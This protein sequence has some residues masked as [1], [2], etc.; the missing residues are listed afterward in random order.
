M[1]LDHAT[2]RD[3]EIFAST[4]GKGPAVVGLLDHTRTRIG[5]LQLQQ[6]L[7]TPLADAG[8]IVEVQD[9]GRV[10]SRDLDAWRAMIDAACLD[11]VQ[12]YLDLRWQTS[13]RGSAVLRSVE[14][15][16]LRVRHPDFLR[17]ISR[18][19]LHLLAFL[20]AVGDLARRLRA[21][22]SA[23]L[24]ASGM[25]LDDGLAAPPVAELE[26]LARRASSR[27]NH[28]ALDRL[29]R[30]TARAACGELVR[31]LGDLEALWSLAAASA[32][33]GWTYPAVADQGLE[34]RG[35]VH[36][37]LG[38]GA[39]P[40]DLVLDPRTR[41]C[42]VT[43]PNMAGKSTFLKAVGIAIYLAHLG[44]G[45]PAASMRFAPVG[46]LFTSVQISDSLSAGESFYL[47]EVRRMR[48]LAQVLVE[49]STALAIVDEPF[50]GTNAHDAADATREVVT[51]LARHEGAVVFVASHLAEVAPHLGD[52]PEVRRL[53][54][55]AELRD[56]HPTFDYRLRPGVSDQRLGMPLLRQ[57]GV[58]ELLDQRLPGSAPSE[59]GLVPPV[60]PL[61]T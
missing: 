2:L 55:T 23:G 60:A 3:L 33:G 61:G 28:L 15:L 27:A 48:A 57:E 8:S 4:D 16:S 36:P 49:V 51:R 58:I 46:A 20:G 6:R 14:G 59:A 39:V 31:Q 17:D 30:G 12:G 37:L 45:V 41:V 9:A 29:A 24:V 44:C 40:N 11:E 7:R 13:R 50:R 54:F 35:L 38:G 18:G 32:T 56:G 10:L 52:D 34:C 42:F 19:R 25:R 21:S 47:A 43:G 1:R 26:R 5:R 53:Q 22:E